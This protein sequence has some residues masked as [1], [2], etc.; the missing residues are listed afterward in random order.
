MKQFD[1]IPCWESY[2]MITSKDELHRYKDMFHAKIL[3]IKKD[4]T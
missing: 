2:F 1:I 4:R 3:F